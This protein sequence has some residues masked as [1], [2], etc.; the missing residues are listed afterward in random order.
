METQGSDTELE[1][2]VIIFFC[3]HTGAKTS[4]LD[5][6]S[7]LFHDLGIDGEDALELLDAFSKKFDVD[8]SQFPFSEYFGNEGAISPL[9]LVLKLLGKSP[10][11]DK[12]FL[13][14]SDLINAVKLGV[15]KN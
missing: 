10:Y 6:N 4:T 3:N 14:V 9:D 2:R 7:R 13:S 5:L 11:N 15:L 8:V 1:Q 12:K